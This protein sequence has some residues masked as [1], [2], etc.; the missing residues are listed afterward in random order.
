MVQ[1]NGRRAGTSVPVLAR[2]VGTDRWLIY[3]QPTVTDAVPHRARVISRKLAWQIHEKSGES[4]DLQSQGRR[5]D[6]SPD[7]LERSRSTTEQSRYASQ[8]YELA[9]GHTESRAV[10]T[11]RRRPVRR[12]SETDRGRGR[13]PIAAWTTSRGSTACS[14]RLARVRPVGAPQAVSW[15]RE[16]PVSS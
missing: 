6:H 8:L 3:R 5:N 4:D 2:L 11:S 13:R 10:G 15:R 12:S 14:S 16:R 7:S 9:T 1:R